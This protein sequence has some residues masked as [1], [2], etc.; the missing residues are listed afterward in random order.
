MKHTIAILSFNHFSPWKN[1][2]SLQCKVTLH[3]LPAEA[4]ITEVDAWTNTSKNRSEY[5]DSNIKTKMAARLA[6]NPKASPAAKEELK[7]QITKEVVADYHRRTPPPKFISRVAP[8][9]ASVHTYDRSRLSIAEANLAKC[10]FPRLTLQW[11]SA[12][13]TSWNSAVIDSLVASWLECYNSRGVPA[14]YNI[15]HSD[16]TPKLAKEILTKWLS[17]K[18]RQFRQEEKDKELI[19]TEEGCQKYVN[20]KLAAKDRKAMQALRKKVNSF[21]LPN[22][23]ASKLTYDILS[24]LKLVQLLSQNIQRTS[25]Q[26]TNFSW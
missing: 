11:T 22:L 25:P 8:T 23:L 15:P 5:L 26:L 18:R 17:N 7:K 16:E 4:E 9:T 19:S 24:L 20:N 6:A 21:S 1:T 13:A 3:H 14:L 2:L 10:G 12:L